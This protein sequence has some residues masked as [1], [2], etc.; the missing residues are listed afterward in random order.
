MKKLIYF[1]LTILIVACSSND[2]NSNT[3]NIWQGA[4]ITFTKSDNTDWTLETN[5]DRITN[6]VWITRQNNRGLF[7]IKVET[8]DTDG[9]ACLGPEPSDTE[10]AY[11]S[12]VNTSSLTFQP[13]GD[14]IECEFED[15]VDGQ[16]MVLHLITDNIYIDLKFTS[17]SSGMGN[18]SGGGGFSYERSTAN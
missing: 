1:A 5:Q 7:N 13:L 10:W 2:D 15:I 11:G 8:S 18:G 16:D 9:N 17:W 4:K 12:I 6:N 3:S 14:L